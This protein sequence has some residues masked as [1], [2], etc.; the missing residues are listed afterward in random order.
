MTKVKEHPLK[1]I[2][3]GILA[4]QVILTA[5]CNLTL[6]DNNIDCDNAKLF[7]H[8]MNMWREK[9]LFLPGW[10]YTTTLELDCSSILALPLYGILG[11]IYLAY[12]VA[13]ILFVFLMIA[14]LFYMFAGEKAEYPLLAANLVCIPYSL[15]MLSYFN[16]MFFCGSQYIVKILI[17]LLFV[18]IVLQMDSKRAGN[19]RKLIVM[20]VL[21]V[22]LVLLTSVSSGVYVTFTGL[23]PVMVAYALYKLLKYERIH[24]LF[25]LLFAMTVLCL[26]VGVMV[27]NAVMG[28]ARGNS[29]MVLVNVYQALANVSSC[30]F[31]I[32]ELFGGIAYDMTLPILSLKGIAIVARAC[33]AILFVVCGIIAGRRVIKGQADLRMLLLASIGVWN[34]FVLLITNTRAGSAT[35]EFRYHLIG[36]IPLMCVT[37]IILLD[38]LGRLNKVQQII[39][40]SCGA[41]IILVVT[42]LSFG[43]VIRHEDEQVELKELCGYLQDLSP[44][45]V[46]MY[47]GSNDADMCRLISGDEE[48]TYLCVVSDGLTYA[49]DYH[50]RYVLGPIQSENAIMVADNSI[51]DFGEQYE[52]FGYTFIRFAVVG[53]R[54]L[55][56]FE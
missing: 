30:I 21:Y 36:M 46:Y 55:Y 23:I 41:M 52:A 19:Q 31:G 4:V 39:F 5:F 7:V 25:Y 47:D 18:G 22:G 44:E 26:I 28:G 1:Y 32:F 29:S 51:Y 43:T 27:N 53:N 2:L 13:N 42:A 17:P 35:Y 8:T 48:I 20:S 15:G 24:F 14:V 16:M 50:S 10:T 38:G 12:G 11:N 9:S 6:I 54:S 45:Y 37:S 56:Y 34:L 49:Y 40:A 3:I 33:F